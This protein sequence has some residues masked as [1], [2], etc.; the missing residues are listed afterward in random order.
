MA[1]GGHGSESILTVWEI[2]LCVSNALDK[3]D[4]CLVHGLLSAFVFV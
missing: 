3:R 1:D 4:Y 2:G